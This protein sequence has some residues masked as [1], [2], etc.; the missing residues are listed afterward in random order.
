MNKV[1]VLG[2]GASGIMA[3]IT[4]ARCGAEVTLVE[5]NHRIG[6]KLLMTGNGR[7]NFTN[8][9]LKAD[10]YN[11]AFVRDALEAFSPTETIA[12]FK[13]TGLIS[14]LEE[15]GRVYPASGQASAVLEVLLL[16]LKR[17]NV[18]IVCDFNVN[19]ISKSKTGFE[20]VS[21]DGEKI[22]ADK[23]IASFG[24]KAAP[25]TG[26][27]GGGYRL[28]E[29][30]GHSITPVSCALVQLKTDRSIKGV[31]AKAMV[32]LGDKKEAGEVQF[33]EYG[34]SGIP[35]FNLSRYA[36]K[37]DIITLDLM[38]D[39]SENELFEYL[40]NR[41]EQSLETYLVGIVN[42][43]LGQMLLKDCGIGKL[44]RNSRELK[45][46]EIEKIAKTIKNWHFTVTGKMPWENAQVTRGGVRLLEVFSKTMESKLIRGCYITGEMLDIDA[47]CGGFNLQ[48]A[49]SSGF[50]A[51]KS[52][53]QDGE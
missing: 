15:G 14:A 40:K 38:P 29:S 34:L 21:K 23:V 35:V 24:G 44:S 16:E 9:N 27:D 1:A 43:Q 33:T 18:K 48:W 2:G 31:R 10:D 4:A 19:K 41:N 5:K 6:K 8:I 49:W 39:Y 46:F 25:K 53:A 3:A 12:F 22:L 13:E 50:A 7:C 32:T 30:I 17:R 28:L 11:S 26:S 37:G 52:A 42:K 51:G 20:I 45:E 47:P 36:Q